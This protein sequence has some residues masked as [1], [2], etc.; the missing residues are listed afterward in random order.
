M[1]GTKRSILLATADSPDRYASVAA[2]VVQSSAPVQTARFGDGRGA[3]PAQ[4]AKYGVD[5]ELWRM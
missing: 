1:F 3:V 4:D 5:V 2:Q